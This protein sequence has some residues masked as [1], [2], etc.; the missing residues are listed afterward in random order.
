MSANSNSNSE[1]ESIAM[2]ARSWDLHA[3]RYDGGGSSSET[4]DFGDPLFPTDEELDLI[5]PVQG[6]RVL[7]VGS[8]ACACGIALARKGAVVT[9]VDV[10]RE[11]LHRGTESAREAGVEVRTALGN[12]YDLGSVHDE[13]FELVIAIASFQ[14]VPDLAKALTSAFQA[15]VPKGRLVFSI[16]HPVMDAFDAAVLSV[17]DGADPKYSYRGPVQWKWDPDDEFEFVTYR[18]TVADII[19]DVVGAGFQIER[20]D[21][22]MPVRT[23]PDWSRVEQEIRT[24]FPSFLVV[25]A[26]K[27]ENLGAPASI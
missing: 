4:F 2:N 13:R 3:A 14:Y 27:G 10:S 23:E 20:L 11:Q 16:P 17:E 8:G 1:S 21:E 5:G 19:N 6:K 7:E 15:L 25:S 9:C 26:L 18:R 22:L 24:R 12:A